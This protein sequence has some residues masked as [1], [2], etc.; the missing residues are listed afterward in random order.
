MRRA[1][2]RNAYLCLLAITFFTAIGNTGLISIMPA[3]GRVIGISDTLVASIFSLS[4][5]VWATASPWWARVADRRG[6]KPLILV[7]LVGFAG[8]MVGCGVAIHAGLAGLLAPA[9]TFACFFLV[10]ASYGLFGS[11]SATASQAYVADRTE[12]FSRVRA[13]SGQAGALSLGT[14]VGPALA[15]FLILPPL[16]L[17]MPMFLFGAV[18]LVVLAMSAWMIPPEARRQA[19]GA[20]DAG[21]APSRM[22]RDAQ[23]APFFRFGIILASAQAMNLYTLGFVV[24]DRLGGAPIAAQKA[25][26]LAMVGGALASLIAQWVVVGWFRLTPTAM[27]QWGGALAAAGN[28]LMMAGA[29]YASLAAGFAIASFGYGLGRPGFAAG[30]SLAAGATEQG[31]VAGTVSSIAGASIV[32]PPIVAV[33]LYEWWTPAPFVLASAALAAITVYS[34]RNPAISAVRPNVS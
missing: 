6:R 19:G 34:L 3:I 23:V 24:I 14:I 33:L 11:A 20:G 18:G 29:D 2:D 13:L 10:R 16:A 21:A 26:G 30:A 8:S 12:G 17:A 22:W 32:A 9:S 1:L 27:T 31:R 5:L 15:P 4:A 25:V 28:L 7:G